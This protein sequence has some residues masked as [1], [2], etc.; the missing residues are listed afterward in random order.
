M[1]LKERLQN[2]GQAIRGNKPDP[3]VK[4]VV[5]EVEAKAKSVMGGFL[6]F[7]PSKDITT[8]SSKY[9]EADKGWVFR[10]NDLI[11]T[12]IGA[13][14]LE[15]YSVKAVRDEVIFDRIYTHKLLDALNRFN[16]YTSSSDGFYI[17]QS[18]K[19]LTGDSF[20]YVDR[21]GIDINEITILQPDKV[22]IKLGKVDGT[23]RV[24][25]AY[26][27]K[28]IIKGEQVEVTYE[29]D[30]IVHF[31]KPNSRNPYRG[32]SAVEAAAEAIDT[33]T[34]AIDANKKLFERGLIAQL[35]LVTE[36]SL[37]PEQ[38]KQL[39]SEFRN[40][41]GGTQ[42]AY[43]V[44]IFSGGI[45]PENVQMTNKDAQFLEQQEWLRD[46]I[47]S[48]FGNPKSLLTTDDVNMANA[49]ATILNWKRTTI[50]SEMKAIVDTLNE[51]LVPLYGDNLLLGFKDPVEEDESA[52]IADVKTLK[53]SDIISRNEAREELGREPVEGGNEF[54]FQRGERRAEQAVQIPPALRH[55]NMNSVI[56]KQLES[57]AQ[58]KRIKAMVRPYAEKMVKGKKKE[59]KRFDA[60]QVQ[61]YY[62][63]QIAIVETVELALHDRIQS[64]IKKVADK[65][66]D[67]VP[68]EVANAKKKLKK[69][70]LL[71]EEE[72]IVEATLDFT[73]LLMEVAAQ[74][75]TE[76]L[77]LINSN[78]PYVPTNIR[79]VVER[80]V[81][82][83]ATS[84][85][86]TDRDKLT[87]LITE[88]LSNGQSVPQI[89]QSIRE[90]FETFSKTQTDRIVR[91][92][93]LRTSNISAVDA[94]DQSDEVVGKQWLTAGG[95]DAECE[96]YEGK[97]VSLKGNFYPTEE[98]ADG[99]PPIHP[100][101]RCTILP[102]L[103]GEMANTAEVR[104]KQLEAEIEQL[105]PKVKEV[106]DV[107]KLK[108]ELGKA[109]SE[110]ARLKKKNKKLEEEKQELEGF[111][112]EPQD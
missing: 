68:T 52:K 35:M 32:K 79:K 11:A 103:K 8:V 86:E 81:K 107:E 104:V 37:T 84:M 108:E 18:H 34:M 53:D 29:P 36:K 75:G 94:W 74:A 92:E 41:Y 87:A 23:R 67:Q 4:E 55:V 58:Y 77:N 10:N 50:T 60:E 102:V 99:D 14:E 28:D 88:G 105:I 91:T 7:A 97:I 39:H 65:A 27:F 17:T 73:P 26:V 106:E 69:K 38:L 70:A 31:R 71:N 43:K 78:K 21:S 9:L 110:K 111:L 42:N 2:I 66:I 45:K 13:M 83:F 16:E 49:D 12:E 54:D 46:K 6:D 100:N 62:A 64:F 85:I 89:S 76:A 93:V 15:L 109:E 22:T 82:M 19:K 47:C 5:K 48:I 57:V 101:C 40:T 61:T 1:T 33:D 20:W 56:N 90:T 96:V 3:V 112:D 95:A 51:F 30:E 44:P 72:L 80:R 24:I 98:F 63:K 59:V 25:Q